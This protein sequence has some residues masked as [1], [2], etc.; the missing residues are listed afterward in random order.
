MF[1]L[2]WTASVAVAA[3]AL[4]ACAHA[5]TVRV[6]GD[7]P[8]IQGGLDAAAEGDTVLV[9][10]GTY[11][12]L[13][14]RDLD[15]GGFDRVLMSEEGADATVIDCESASGGLYFDDRESP[16]AVVS[17]FTITRGWGDGGIYCIY[18]SPT[19]M[20]CSIVANQDFGIYSFD[21]FPTVL[22]CTI[23]GNYSP[24][25]GGGVSCNRSPATLENCEIVLNAANSRGGGV[26]CNGSDLRIKNCTIA[27]NIV[28]GFEVDAG[29]IHCSNYS[30][31]VIANCIIWG[32]NKEQILAI[33]SSPVVTYSDVEGWWP[34]QG[35]IS[36]DPRFRHR[37]GFDYVLSPGS[38]CIDS[39]TGEDDGI[40]WASLHSGYGHVNTQAPDMG[41]YGGPGNIGWLP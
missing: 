18:S 19:I 10:A 23:S 11:T 5:A 8:T 26:Y 30:F 31:P 24:N 17:G 37:M 16:A 34:G 36:A 40:D 33:S 41:A 6:P 4:A 7:Q 12:G 28:L 32:N 9:A 2:L 39:G 27:G 35:N 21:A 25:N 1:R 20:N 38:P 15:F 14:N 29:G 3:C 22:N 13:G